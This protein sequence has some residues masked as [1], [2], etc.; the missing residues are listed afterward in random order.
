MRDALER[1]EKGLLD[2]IALPAGDASQ[3][4]SRLMLRDG[5]NEFV[6][7]ILCFSEWNRHALDA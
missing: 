4:D 2:P 3:R 5:E 6:W 7:R 1:L